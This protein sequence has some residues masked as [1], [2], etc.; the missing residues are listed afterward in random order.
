VYTTCAFTDTHGNYIPAGLLAETTTA[1]DGTWSLAVIQTQALSHS[2]TFQFDYPLG[3]NQ[4]RSAKYAAV[5]PAQ[6]TA[7]FSDLVNLGSGTAA[8][9]Y[10]PT[11]DAL[12]EGT[13]N[14]YFTAARAQAAISAT[15]PL[16]DTAGVIS[17]QTAS[18]TQAGALSA[19]DWT[20]FNSKQAALGYTPLNAADNLSDVANA[21]TARTNL[22]LGTAATQA[23]SAFAQTAN[24]LSDLANEATAR[25]NLGLGTIATQAATTGSAVQK[26]NGTGG[27]T[28]ATAKTDYWD[29]TDLAGDSGTGGT[30]GLAPAPGAGDA[31]AGKFLKADGTWAAPPSGFSNPMT[32]LGDLIYENATPTP[33]RLA[34]STSAT[35][36]FLTQTGTGSVSAAPAW[37]TI[38]AG[39]VPTL[40]QNTTGTAAN[41]TASSNSTLTT[42]SALS[43]PSS[44]VTGLLP[45]ISWQAVQTSAFNAVAGNGYPVN[46]SSAGI[47]ATLP[48]SPSTGQFI[49]FVDYAGTFANNNLTLALNGNKFNGGTSNV[50]LTVDREGAIIVYIDATQGWVPYVGM[51]SKTPIQNYSATYLVVAGG[52]GGGGQGGGGGAGGYQT[53]SG[54]LTAG[55]VYTV[56]V[57]GGGSAGANAHGGSGSNSVLSGSGLTTV[58]STGGG[59]GGSAGDSTA[60]VSGGSGG[61]GAPTT[62]TAG[63]SGTAGQGNAGGSGLGSS[64][65]WGGGGGGAGSTGNNATGSAGGNGGS[66]STFN[67]VAYAGGGG[68]GASSTNTAGSGGSG[69]GGAAANNGGNG[70]A[71][72]ANTGGG[73]GA[74]AT[75]A[76]STGG[77]GGSGVVILSVPTANYSGTT[78]GSPTVTTSGANTIIKFTTSGSYTA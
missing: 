53:G 58:T 9:A 39:D 41:I 72:S 19:A 31:A 14:L 29:T 27:L 2:V 24:N 21:A 56:T 28:P 65:Y 40:N 15:S 68:G 73:G 12:P 44:Q 48:A 17:I 67:S 10:A 49:A 30:H 57:G 37:G 11:T 42:L 60:G 32:T 26:A 54:T 69:G 33:A 20:T 70:T 46:T 38:A 75:L 3:N 1:A 51:N 64:P 74:G 50:T 34:G 5:I 35:K 16:S 7:N 55:S 63:G 43:L 78:T 62:S 71:G 36:Q 66:G 8:L 4:S 47:T 76:T 45:Y 23:S 6:S 77:A 59:G 18:S 61:G 25:T 52:G 13:T 22:G